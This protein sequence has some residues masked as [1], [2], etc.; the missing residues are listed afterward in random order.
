M[1]QAILIIG[2]SVRAMMQSALRAGLEPICADCFG[3]WDLSNSCVGM[4]I[5]NYPRDLA[6]FVRRGPDVPWMYTGG[7]ENYPD[8]VNQISRDRPLLGNS[9]SVLR[10]VRDPFVVSR[11]LREAG[12]CTPETRAGEDHVPADGSW[13]CK[14][15]KSSGGLG[16]RLH[17]TQKQHRHDTYFQ[18]RVAG[19]ACSAV[20]LATPSRTELLGITEQIV[21]QPW[22]GA[23]EFAYAGSIGPLTLDGETEAEVAR[24][25][26]VLRNRFGLQGLFGVDAILANRRWWTIEINPRYTA[27]VEILERARGIC[28]AGWHVAAC[29]GE[30]MASTL[31][32]EIRELHGKAIV[33]ATQP[34]LASPEFCSWVAGQNGPAQRWPPIADLPYANTIFSPGEPILTVFARGNSPLCVADRLAGLL[35]VVRCRL[36]PI[37]QADRLETLR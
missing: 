27:S 37:G 25:G 29:S 8:L 22:T 11:V 4:R 32:P 3:D 16:V 19:L 24:T 7:L 20:F 23:P 35:S 9:G 15:R 28:A 12:L 6:E 18:R 1:T 14:S 33:Y 17:R 34:V 31:N 21:N 5:R 36:L 26:E 2:A 30:D 13:F 10:A